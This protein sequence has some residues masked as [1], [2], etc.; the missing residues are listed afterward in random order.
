MPKPNIIVN[1]RGA[2][3]QSVAELEARIL[4]YRRLAA[5]QHLSV[6]EWNAIDRLRNRCDKLRK[7]SGL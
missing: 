1:S 4:A 6:A 2:R 3:Q 5:H 7:D